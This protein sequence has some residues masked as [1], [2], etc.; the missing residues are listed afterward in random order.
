[1][2][3][4]FEARLLLTLWDLGGVE[5]LKGKLNARLSGPAKDANAACSNLV[6]AGAVE[7]SADGK[8][9]TLADAGKVM[10]QSALQD[11]AFQFK[12]QIGAKMANALLNWYRLQGSGPIGVAPAEAIGSYEAFKAVALETFEGLNRDFNLDNLVPIYRIRRA[13][14]ERVARS[15]FNTW[16][17]EMQSHDVLQ[18]LEGSVEDSASDKIEDSITTKI[19]GLRCYAKRLDA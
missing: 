7:V 10:L 4:N 5:I 8:R 16:L 9:V 17:L 12:A 19:S 13:I 6:K 14:G 2:T 3:T 1:M 15:D 18:L 11:K